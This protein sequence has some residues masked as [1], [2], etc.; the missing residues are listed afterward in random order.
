ML[1]RKRI[2][3]SCAHCAYGVKLDDDSVLCAKKGVRSILGKCHKFKY[4]PIKR[5]PAKPKAMDLT[6]YDT[7]DFNL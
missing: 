1:F 6:K 2:E 5:I 7:E 4:D 3:R